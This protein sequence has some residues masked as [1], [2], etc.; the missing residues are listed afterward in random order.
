[1]LLTARPG[2]ASRC[3]PKSLHFSARENA[4]TTPSKPA[5][6]T[7]CASQNCTS[8]RR[9]KTAGRCPRP[10]SRGRRQRVATTACVL[11]LSVLLLLLLHHSRRLLAEQ[12][13]CEFRLRPPALLL[14]THS[15]LLQVLLACILGTL[16]C[17]CCC[18]RLAVVALLQLRQEASQ[19][20][21]CGP[22][23]LWQA[24]QHPRPAGMRSGT[25]TALDA[26]GRP[27]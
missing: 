27:A 15:V 13:V 1:M 16:W 10:A 7:T 22:V 24:A 8:A 26:A 20:R 18:R 14:L 25:P 23:Q 11:A 6:R 19:L 12:A 21:G 2:V 3:F 5:L 4:Y 17:C 9:P